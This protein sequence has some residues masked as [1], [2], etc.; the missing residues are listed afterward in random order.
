[1]SP[2]MAPA[3]VELVDLN[4]LSLGFFFALSI[5]IRHISAFMCLLILCDPTL[6]LEPNPIIFQA[7]SDQ[8]LFLDMT[9]FPLADSGKISDAVS[10]LA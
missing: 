3:F 5:E 9:D 2:Y 10:G 4:A 7:V 8:Y 6:F 1:M